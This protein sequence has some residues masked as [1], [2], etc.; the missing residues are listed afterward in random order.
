MRRAFLG[1][2]AGLLGLYTV[3]TVRGWDLWPS[4]KHKIPENVRQAPG[5]YRS[6]AYWR[7]GK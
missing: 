4:R 5:G 6:F 3:A 2:V 1:Y 7:G